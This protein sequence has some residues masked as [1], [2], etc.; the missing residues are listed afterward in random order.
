MPVSRQ[1]ELS[2]GMQAILGSTQSPQLTTGDYVNCAAGHPSRSTPLTGS[3]WYPASLPLL[4]QQK[5]LCASESHPSHQGRYRPPVCSHSYQAVK[6]NKILNC[7]QDQSSPQPHRLFQSH[8]SPSKPCISCAPR[9]ALAG[10][11]RALQDL[12]GSPRGCGEAWSS[13][14]E[15]SCSP[16]CNSGFGHH[17]LLLLVPASGADS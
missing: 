13:A 15:P 16:A 2:A 12:L 6:S 10:A 1:P 4:L 11:H 14:D 5:S 7:S 3:R 9:P 8:R 17:A